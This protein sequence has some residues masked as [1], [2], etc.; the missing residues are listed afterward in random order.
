MDEQEKIEL[1]AGGKLPAEF[2][3]EEIA[4]TARYNLYAA[5]CIGELKRESVNEH[6]LR[7]RCAPRGQ[8][9]IAVLLAK[10]NRIPPQYI[11]VDILEKPDFLLAIAR[12]VSLHGPGKDKGFVA[13]FPEGSLRFL[14]LKRFRK[15]ANE[16]KRLL[17]LVREVLEEGA[18]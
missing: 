2:L 16:I 7:L 11:T 12:T 1:A 6:I 5:A 9:S 17:E 15:P 8:D 4:Y 18:K 13:R 10:Q 3:T 14:A